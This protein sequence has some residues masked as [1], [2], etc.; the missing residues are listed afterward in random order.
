MNEPRPSLLLLVPADWE[1]IHDGLAELRRC[2]AED[3]GAALLLR[4]STAPMRS[5][6]PLYVGYWEPW[7]RRSAG[8]NIPLLVEQA[9]YTLD[10]LQLEDV[11]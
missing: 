7:S 1:A 3:Y 10:W 4:L 8:R 6:L 5:P 9:F 2:L 11:G